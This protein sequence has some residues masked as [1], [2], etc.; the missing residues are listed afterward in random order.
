MTK[1]RPYDPEYERNTYDADFYE[2]HTKYYEKGIPNFVSFLNENVE[3]ESFADLGC[4]SGAFC[5]PFQATKD[6][7]GVDFSVGAEKFNYLDPKNYLSA[8]LSK[9]LNLNRTYD[10]VMSLEVWEHLLPECEQGYLDNIFALKPKTLIISCA[11]PGQWGRHHYTPRTGEEVVKIVSSRGY[12]LNQGLT[13]KFR[14]IKKL[15]GFYKKNT[16][17]FNPTT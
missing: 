10:L 16:H 13:E 6:V 7:L 5:A 17:V 12:S 3:F 14:T 2:S 8:D 15:A 1:V 9:P 11:P 4:G